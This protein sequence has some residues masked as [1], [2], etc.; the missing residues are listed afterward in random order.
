[1]CE[2]CPQEVWSPPE[3]AWPGCWERLLA[4]K[5]KQNFLNPGMFYHGV[6]LEAAGMRTALI[7]EVHMLHTGSC[8]PM[9]KTLPQKC[10]GPSSPSCS[11]PSWLPEE[12]KAQRV[13]SI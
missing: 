9:S 6:D 8:G 13:P 2:L 7:Q 5:A 4:V 12:E 3:G 1:M 10:R 11:A